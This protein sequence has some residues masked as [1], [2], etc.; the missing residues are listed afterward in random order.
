M[1]QIPHLF[2]KNVTRML[3]QH[4]NPDKILIKSTFCYHL[5]SNTEFNCGTLHCTAIAYAMHNP[6]DFYHVHGK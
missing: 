3:H 1:R 4:G 6:T 2:D 5:Y